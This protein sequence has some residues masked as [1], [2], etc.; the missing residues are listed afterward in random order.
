[1]RGD[2]IF[3]GESDRS[4]IYD[5]LVTRDNAAFLAQDWSAVADDFVDTG[6]FGIHA[7][8]NAD[9]ARWQLGFPSLD[10]YRNEWLQQ[11]F[12]FAE[13][14]NQDLA[15]AALAAAA[16]LERIEI[17]GDMAFAHKCFDGIMPLKNGGA[18]RLLWQTRYVCRR[19]NG[20]WK[21]ASFVGYLPYGGALKPGHFVAATAQH[22]TAGPYTPVV[23]VQSGAQILVLSGQ[24]P[25]DGEGN[26]V[27][28]TLEEQA[29]ITLDNC[30]AQLHAAGLDF[31]DVF[32]ATIYLT[33]LANWA[34]FNIIYTEY[35]SAPYPARTAIQTG[36]LPGL[37]VEIEMWAARR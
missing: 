19:E 6:F 28:A 3:D 25:L 15:A 14:A 35:L 27:G 10:R 18:D 17:D 16:Q 1:M 8:R 21:I 34:A 31:V 23:G 26:V 24:A 22:K 30:L 33:D 32:K 12:D 29:R 13:R 7:K 36:L 5:M 20:R 11:A 4:A 9:P 2:I 37:L